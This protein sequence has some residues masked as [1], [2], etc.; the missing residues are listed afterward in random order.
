MIRVAMRLMLAGL[1]VFLLPVASWAGPPARLADMAWL[2]GSWD[3]VGIGG[4]AATESWSPA[5]GGQIPGH[6]RQ[7]SADGTVMFYELLALAEKDGSLVLRLKHF[8]ADLTGWEEKA[9][10]REFPLTATSR[11][12]WEF[13]GIGYQ[14]EGRNRMTVTVL[15]RNADKTQETLVFKLRRRGR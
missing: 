10:V 2:A 11:D 15:V 9:T 12:R 3:G 4:A 13:S 8:N 1:G 6:F 5:A 14:R 7:L